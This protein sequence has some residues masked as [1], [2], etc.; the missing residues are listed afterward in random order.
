MRSYVSHLIKES[1]DMVVYLNELFDNRL[2]DLPSYK[3]HT[4]VKVAF[5]EKVKDK[6]FL[7]DSDKRSVR[8]ALSEHQYIIS[9]NQQVLAQ[10]STV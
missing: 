6:P 2:L 3:M 9:T 1:T 7:I 10:L 4:Q 5:L 8:K